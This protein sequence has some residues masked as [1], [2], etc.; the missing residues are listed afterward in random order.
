[1]ATKKS[2]KEE[3]ELEKIEETQPAEGEFGQ[4]LAAWDFPEFV[5]EKKGKW[6][7]IS[8]A[9]IFLL[10][11]VYSYFE[12]NFLFMIIITLFIFA[13]F[14]LDKKD[15]QRIPIALA[16]DGLLLGDKFIDYKDLENFY[17]IYYPP[18]IKN[19]YFQP[20]NQLKNRLIISLEKQNPVEVRKILLN[21]LPEDLEKEEIPASET[22]S[23]FFKL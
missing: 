22:V 21:H 9:V 18:Q 4:I 20:K 13:Y 17:I 14:S 2:K 10:M 16:E 11:L 6:W 15:P 8:F 5:K 7:Y 1:M 3:K 23:R 12:E 19:L